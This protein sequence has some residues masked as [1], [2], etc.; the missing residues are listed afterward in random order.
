MK[1]FEIGGYSKDGT[2]GIWMW[3]E[4]VP[5]LDTNGEDTGIDMMLLDSE[6]LFNRKRRSEDFDLKVISLCLLLSSRLIYN[7]IGHI[8]DQAFENLSILKSIPNK[9]KVKNFNESV[10]NFKNFFPDFCW[11]L[12][13]FEME[14]KALTPISYLEQCLEVEKSF[15]GDS[16]EKN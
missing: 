7:Q 12:R 8:S 3:S 11:V 5:M 16:E 6:G 10:Q 1:G 2:R 14:F 13:D 15:S 4:L 9:I